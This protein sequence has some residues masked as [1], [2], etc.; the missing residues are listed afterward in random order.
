VNTA[1]KARFTAKPQRSAL[2]GRLP[3]PY[4]AGMRGAQITVRCDCGGIG[5]VPHGERWKCA[6]C[7]RTWNTAQI[8]ADEY[9]GIMRDMR[10]LRIK[11]IAT[12]L[13]LMV[14]VLVLSLVVGLRLLLLLPVL[15]SFWF[16]FYMPRWRRQVR[17]RARNLRRWKLHPE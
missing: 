1:G 6:T 12:A 11:V 4:N 14:P 5:Y 10:Q 16:L 17:E 15:M 13:G 3:G 9:W 2:F 8:P 7:G